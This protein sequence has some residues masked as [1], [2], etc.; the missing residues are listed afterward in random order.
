[1]DPRINKEASALTGDLEELL[2]LGF[3]GPEFTAAVLV[4]SQRS[5]ARVASWPD[6]VGDEGPKPLD[7]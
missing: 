2:S 1:M 5:L 4:L 3:E 6:E 7:E